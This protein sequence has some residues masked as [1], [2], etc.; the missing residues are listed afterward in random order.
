MQTFGVWGELK[1]ARDE[2]S[3]EVDVSRLITLAEAAVCSL[4][5]AEV[6]LH[7][8]R[9]MAVTTKFVADP[10]KAKKVLQKNTNVLEAEKKDLFGRTFTKQLTCSMRES[11]KLRQ[12]LQQSA[13]CKKKPGNY[14][15]N[16]SR[17]GYAQHNYKKQ[18]QDQ[19]KPFS[20]GPRGGTSYGGRDQGQG[21]GKP[22]YVSVIYSRASSMLFE[23]ERSRRSKG[24][25][26]ARPI[27]G[28]KILHYKE[29]MEHVD[30]GRFQTSHATSEKWRE[31]DSPLVIFA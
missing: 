11:T 18:S 28:C 19:S 12:A 27:R 29:S 24:K 10:K 30:R 20:P 5:Q 31:A 25:R 8:Q 9:R 13:P 26:G 17:G 16:H 6:E 4:G 14:S 23:K 1:N 2:G 21:R 3:Q 15:R 22:R 7:Y